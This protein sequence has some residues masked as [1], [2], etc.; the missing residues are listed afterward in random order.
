MKVAR[1]KPLVNQVECRA[2]F[3]QNKIETAMKKHDIVI[4]A[5][6]SLGSPGSA[7]E[8]EKL[9]DEGK[10]KSIGI[11]NFNSAQGERIIKVVRGKLVLNQSLQLE[12]R[13][14]SPKTKLE[15]ALKKDNILI[16]AFPPA[17]QHYLRKFKKKLEY[18]F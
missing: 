5:Y 17:M 10:A 9:V 2:Y 4:M 3:Q 6:G 14:Y 16:M 18:L 8:M 15:A 11:S 13:A 1:V 7:A 12:C